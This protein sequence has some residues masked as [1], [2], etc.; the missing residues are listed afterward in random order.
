VLQ[1]R[2][3]KSWLLDRIENRDL[4]YQDEQPTLLTK[5]QLT[6]ALSRDEDFVSVA[7][8]YAPNKDLPS[9]VTAL[10]ADEHV[11][12]LAALRYRP[13]GLKKRADWEDVWDRQRQEDTAEDEREKG[14]IRDSIPVPSKYTSADFLKPSYWRARGKLD[15]P[16]ER[17]ISYA[18]TTTGTP[19]LYGWAGW[20]HR[21]QAQALTT[22]FTNHTTTTDELTA[23]L[24]GLLELQPWLGQWHGEFDA[25]Y[26]MSPAAFFAGYRSQIQGEHGLTDDDL[27]AWRPTAAKRGRRA[28]KKTTDE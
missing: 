25:L 24:A 6:D 4:W 28:A 14:K 1:E 16:K 10:L 9:V 19:D 27:R 2:A 5:A 17:F 8:I 21:E 7:G 18:T 13:S 23:F 20:D 15:V 26:G 11:P 22:Y 12:F 3:L